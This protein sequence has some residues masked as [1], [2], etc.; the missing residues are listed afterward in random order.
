M[1]NSI[2]P[3]DMYGVMFIGGKRGSGKSFLAST[4]ENPT[5][6]CFIDFEEKGK[7]LHQQLNFGEYHSVA[8]SENLFNQVLNI[9]E[10]L[11]PDKFTV[12]IFDN[13]TH[14]EDAMKSE[15]KRKPIDYAKQ[16]GIN[17]YN[18]SSG[19]F[20]GASA[21]VNKLISYK[22]SS[23]LHQKGVKLI[24]GTAHAKPFWGSGGPIPNKWN[25]LGADRWQDLAILSLILIDGTYAPIPSAIV[26]KEQLGEITFDGENFTKKRRLPFRLPKVDLKSI[27]YYLK[28]PAD[29]KNPPTDEVVSEEERASY[30]DEL[31]D[32]Q[33]EINR[34][35]LEIQRE[36]INKQQKEKEILF[37][38]QWNEAKKLALELT[39]DKS[40]PLPMWIE[41]VIGKFNNQ[42]PQYNQSDFEEMINDSK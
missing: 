27:G 13:V 33:F 24:I 26:K 40:L 5:R 42:Y 18:I 15:V 12:V 14:L 21:V 32:E 31:T 41:D 36:K 34:M 38:N 17:Q 2:L 20:G 8:L 16:F 25:I 35:A 23:P 19:N 1:N 4:M 9:I 7:I 22:I 3:I 37:K 6:V 39:A 28:N 11:E 29:L 10:N 30:S